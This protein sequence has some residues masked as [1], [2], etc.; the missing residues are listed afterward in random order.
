MAAPTAAPPAM[1][2]NVPI[3]LP[4]YPPEM[5]PMAEPIIDPNMAPALAHCSVVLQLLTTSNRHTA[6]TKPFLIAVCF[7]ICANIAIFKKR[8]MEFSRFLS[9]DYPKAK[10]YANRIKSLPYTENIFFLQL[11]HSAITRQGIHVEFATVANNHSNALGRTHTLIVES[12]DIN[13]AKR[14]KS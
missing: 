9:R 2:T 12:R 8:A 3:S 14:L 11:N 13:C 10:R 7:I 1:P 5:P 4:R 6:D